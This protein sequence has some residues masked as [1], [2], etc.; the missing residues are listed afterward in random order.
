MEINGAIQGTVWFGGSAERQRVLANGLVLVIG[1]DT[2]G[3][4]CQ[5]NY[6]EGVF[7]MRVL[8]KWSGYISLRMAG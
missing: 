2:E 4:Y 5:S 8:G 6:M 1:R 7:L 3:D